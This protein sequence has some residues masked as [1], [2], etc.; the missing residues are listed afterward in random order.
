MYGTVGYLISTHEDAVH[1]ELS[2]KFNFFGGYSDHNCFISEYIL[3]I[4]T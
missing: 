2:P 3:Y 4:K 1:L